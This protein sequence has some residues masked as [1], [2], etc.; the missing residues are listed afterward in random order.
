MPKR[1]IGHLKRA[2]RQEERTKITPNMPRL[3]RAA[4]RTTLC[5]GYKKRKE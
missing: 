5:K 3:F 1:E 2:L 4:T